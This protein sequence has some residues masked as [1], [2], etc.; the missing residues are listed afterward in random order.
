MC[1]RRE[2]VLSRQLVRAGTSIGANIEEALAAQSRRD[3]LAKMSLA[4][5][6]ARES[7]YWLRLIGETG[8][9]TGEEI[10]PLL[11]HSTELVRMLTAII[12]STRRNPDVVEIPVTLDARRNS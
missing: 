5:K 1:G 9:A 2:Y 8:L 6:E 12:L 4:R 7:N 10:A 11:A 3:F